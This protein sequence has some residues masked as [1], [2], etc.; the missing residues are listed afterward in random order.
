[1]PPERAIGCVVYCSTTIERPGV[2]RHSEGTRFSIGE[3]SGAISDRCVAFSEAMVA[4]GL[5]CPVEPDIRQ[6]IWI[7]LMGNVAF[8]PISALTRATLAGM[9]R[10]EPTRDLVREAM[11]E[12]LA[13]AAALGSHPDISIDRRI[14]GAERVGEHKTSTLQDLERNR[15]LELDALITAVVEL[16]DL[17][18]VPAPALRMIHALCDLLARST[19]AS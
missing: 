13:I 4:G 16:A 18:G 6:D 5:K 14:D 9:C 2:I 3:P 11:H 7:K 1:M 17:T 19:V 12:T 15:P 8:N 10:H